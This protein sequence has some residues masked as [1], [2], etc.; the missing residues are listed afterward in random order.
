MRKLKPAD[1]VSWAFELLEFSMSP[2][3]TRRRSRRK[4]W[5][6]FSY[7]PEAFGIGLCT[8]RMVG[9]IMENRKMTCTEWTEENGS[10]REPSSRDPSSEKPHG[11]MESYVRPAPPVAG[12]SASDSSVGYI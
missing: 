9:G 7:F 5:H 10:T 8:S 3:I 6:G 4:G 2:V 12:M 1:G 11:P